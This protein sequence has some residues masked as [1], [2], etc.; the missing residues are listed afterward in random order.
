MPVGLF[1]V[2]IG[3]FYPVHEQCHALA[4]YLT[5]GVVT[6][7]EHAKIYW[8]GGNHAVVLFFGYGG[9]MLL[10]GALAMVSRHLGPFWLGATLPLGW[11]AQRSIDFSKLGPAA[12]TLVFILWIA[13]LAGAVVVQWKRFDFSGRVSRSRST[14]A[15]PYSHPQ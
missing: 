14:P 12:D 1:L 2:A 7:L 3:T 8:T 15:G 5:G 13:V 11:Q 6:G 10:Y 4:V 9:E